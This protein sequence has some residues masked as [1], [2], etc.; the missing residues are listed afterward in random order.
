[1]WREQIGDYNGAFVN[2]QEKEIYNCQSSFEEDEEDY[3]EVG[4]YGVE[5]VTSLEDILWPQ[6]CL[7]NV[8]TYTKIVHQ[9][10]KE[11]KRRKLG[12][13][14]LLRG[15]ITRPLQGHEAL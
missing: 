14:F 5:D 13:N 7:L 1:M 4:E 10:E 6:K 15:G 2:S 11:R 8:H 3:N 12:A 9:F